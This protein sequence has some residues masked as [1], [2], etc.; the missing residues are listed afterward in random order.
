VVMQRQVSASALGET[1]ATG[2][3]RFGRFARDHPV[4]VEAPAGVEVIRADRLLDK[5]FLRRASE[6]AILEWTANPGEEDVRAALSRL[7]RRYCDSLGM[8]AV[9]PLASGVA[10]DFSFARCSFLMGE[11][12]PYGVVV[13]LEGAELFTCGERPTTWPV[14]GTRLATVAELRAR[15]QR[16]LFADHVQVAID[17]VLDFVRVSPR[18]LWT[19]MAEAVDLAYD[20]GIDGHSGEEYAPILEDR[21]AMLFGATLAG[22]G[23]PNPMAGTL[24]WEAIPGL[25]RPQ[26]VRLVCCFNYVVPGRPEPYCRTCGIISRDE[27]LMIWGR[28]ARDPKARDLLVDPPP[29]SR[30]S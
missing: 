3:Q 29:G 2:L 28:Y 1:L 26:Q 7:W 8:A 22:V 20:A 21:E 24:E 18:M 10:F 17:H 13:D 9:L 14:Q 23:G 6:R 30:R 27:R 15:V 16:S 4:L 19:T 11:Y 25:K 5:E 12:M